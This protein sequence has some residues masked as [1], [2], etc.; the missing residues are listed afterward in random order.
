LRA[1]EIFAGAGGL[2]LGVSAAGFTHEAVIERDKYACSTIRANQQRR[3]KPVVDWKPNPLTEQD[4]STFDFSTIPEGIEL[5]CGGPP[6][7]PFSLAGKSLGRHDKRDL[8]PEAIRAVRELRPRA[9]VFENVK[10]MLRP[11]QITYSQYVCLQ[12]GYPHVRKKKGEKW[13]EHLSRLERYHTRGAGSEDETYKVIIR[14][15][16]AADYGVPQRRER[17]FFI[18]L[19]GDLKVEWSFPEPTHSREELLIDKFITEN[20]WERH[21]ISRKRRETISKSLRRS[22]TEKASK[23]ESRPLQPWVTVRDAIGDLPMPSKSANSWSVP[24]HVFIPGA[25]SYPGHAGSEMDQPAKTLKAGDHGVPGGE[26]MLIHANGKIRYF[27]VREKA[28]LQTFPDKYHFTGNWTA[29]T[30]QLGNAVPVLLSFIVAR[31]IKNA[32]S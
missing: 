3:V 7:Q 9:F 22:L 32:L 11:T 10:G 8:F 31:S 30:R 23:R 13:K 1:V 29:S 26:N 12:L 21:G 2:A 28:R 25:R 4:I 5:L 17:L 15:V 14:A 16:N 19:R 20:Y 24:N 27:T 18:G 6:C